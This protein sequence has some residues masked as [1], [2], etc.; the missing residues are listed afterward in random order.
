MAQILTPQQII[1]EATAF[2][3][4]DLLYFESNINHWQETI[5]KRLLTTDLYAE[6]LGE[7]GTPPYSTSNQR[8]G[9]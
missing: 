6:F 3:N 1:D 7:A 4:L 2:T 5:L 8:K 9:V